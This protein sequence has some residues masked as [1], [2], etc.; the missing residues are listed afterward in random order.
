MKM[1]KCYLDLK[2]KS[3]CC[4]CKVCATVCPKDAISFSFDDEGFWYPSIDEEKCIHCNKCRNVCPLNTE[5]LS[6]ITDQNQTYA[7]YAKSDDVLKKSASGGMFT[8]LSDV[9][10]ENNGVVF[11]HTYDENCHA[12]CSKA[13]TKSE[14]DK[15]CGS[16]YVQ[17]DMKNIYNDIKE[18]V[19]S[20]RKV[21]FT[22]TPC[23]AEAAKKFLRT[24]NNDN[25]YTC[26]L[27]CHGVPSPKIFAEYVALEEKKAGKKITNVEFR[28]KDN[29]WKMPLLKL[30]NEKELV[31]AR[32]LNADAFN[33]LFQGTDCILRPSCYECRY[34]GKERLEDITIAD[35]WGVQ[36][37]HADMFNDDKGVS[38][39]LVNTE[40]GKTLFKGA[41]SALVAKH[42]PLSDVQ[43]RNTPLVHPSVPFKLRERV[44]REYK[45]HGAKYILKKY[46]FRRNIMASLPV[47]AV[48]KVFRIAKKVFGK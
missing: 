38:L 20:G 6:V 27:V 13:E 4:G 30:S 5:N 14:R 48:R 34:A 1:S 18:A 22:G 26:A 24:S 33:N 9:I 19:V 23:Q 43:E 7:A 10:L 46:M 8:V 29:G 42:V 35:F 39:V 44:F 32:L 3:L 45:K 36:N 28:N 16:K 25:F 40:K 47:R 41:S 37:K 31:A 2:E 11:G 12:V 15:M 17:S 21:L